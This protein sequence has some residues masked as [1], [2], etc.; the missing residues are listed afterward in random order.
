[1]LSAF[2]VHTTILN[3]TGYRAH[4]SSRNISTACLSSANDLARVRRITFNIL[5]SNTDIR[6]VLEKY[7]FTIWM[8]RRMYDV[9]RLNRVRNRYLRENVGVTSVAERI[10][11]RVD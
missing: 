2:L 5:K 7:S 4:S 9:V 6:F 3:H 8:W 11:E 10:R 1:M